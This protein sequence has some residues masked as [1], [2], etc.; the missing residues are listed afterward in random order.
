M[1]KSQQR[2]IKSDI[3]RPGNCQAHNLVWGTAKEN[4]A[5]RKIHGTERAAIKWNTIS[6]QANRQAEA[7]MSK[8]T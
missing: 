3:W 6:L 2:R 1:G 8:R 7:K 4:A 5:D